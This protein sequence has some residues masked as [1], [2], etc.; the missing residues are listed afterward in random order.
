MMK[1]DVRMYFISL[2]EIFSAYLNACL[3]K[4]R[5][6]IIYTGLHFNLFFHINIL[7]AFLLVCDMNNFI[8]QHLKVQYDPEGLSTLLPTVIENLMRMILYTSENI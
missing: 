2:P 5:S 8:C 3:K 7:D 1:I 4:C 6:L